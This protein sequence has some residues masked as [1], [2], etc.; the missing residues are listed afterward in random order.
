M[1]ADEAVRGF[2]GLVALG[3]AWE[4]VDIFHALNVA[5]QR[6]SIG[7]ESRREGGRNTLAY[8]AWL[9]CRELIDAGKGSILPNARK[10]E[11]LKGMLRRPDFVSNADGMLESA[12]VKL[13]AEAEARQAARLAFMMPRLKAGLHPDTDTGFRQG[14]EEKPAPG[15]P[16]QSVPDAYHA[17]IKW[18]GRVGMAT[19]IG[20][21]V[22]L[23]LL[24]G[25]LS[26][27]AGL[28][29]ARR[30]ARSEAGGTSVEPIG[31]SR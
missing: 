18:C 13:R 10:G 6:D 5:L 23:V 8:F 3:N 1:K 7:Y 14:Y 26:R 11:A 22:V 27:W 31:D 12:F 30:R 25:G 17:W 28:R 16:T 15:L 4:S 20:G 19:F 24:V 2:A 9:R 29:D 21:I